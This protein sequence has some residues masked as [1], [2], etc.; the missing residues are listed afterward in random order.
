MKILRKETDLKQIQ[1]PAQVTH[2][3]LRYA[4][5]E[6]EIIKKKHLVAAHR[7]QSQLQSELLNIESQCAM[8]SEGIKEQQQ[9]IEGFQEK[10]DKVEDEIF[11]DFCEEIGLE[12]IHEFENKHVKQQQEIDQKRLEF[13]K[14]KTRL[15][16]QLEYSLVLLKKKLNKINTLKETIQKGGKDID[17]LKKIEDNC[18]QVVDELMAKQKQFKDIFATQNS[19]AEEVQSQIEEEWK[20]FLAIDREIGKLQKEVVII[21]TS[22]EQKCLEKHNM[23]LNC[24]VQ[25]IEI[26]LLLGSLD[27]IIAVEVI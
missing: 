26:T 13:E 14:Q 27:D 4:Q 21:Q 18:L 3:R 19:S 7:E 16:I 23:L 10:I 17:S 15:N 12:N 11:H 24:K 5:S 8:L 6:L 22:L 20:K 2:T 25:D 1:I 9:R